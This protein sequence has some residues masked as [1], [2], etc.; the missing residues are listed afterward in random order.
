MPTFVKNN[1]KIS[2][3]CKKHVKNETTWTTYK[4]YMKNIMWRIKEKTQL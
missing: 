2:E 3:A 4:K 1:M